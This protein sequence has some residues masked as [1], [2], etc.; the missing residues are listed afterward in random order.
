MA[1][2]SGLRAE[3]T[4]IRVLFFARIREQLDCASI[5]L[6]WCDSLSGIEGVRSTLITQGGVHWGTVLSEDN[7][8][9]AVNQQVV[10]ADVQLNDGDEIAF[11]PPVTG[12]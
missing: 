2:G 11:F 9:C 3:T 12:G 1:L 8:I 10:T 6:E 4:V 7:I 5:E